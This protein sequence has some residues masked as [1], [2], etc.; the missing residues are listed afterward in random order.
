MKGVILQPTY[1]PWLGY[2]EMIAAAD[3]FIIYDHVQFVKK[4]WH[5]RN[6]IKGPN[7][8]ILLSVPIKKAPLNTPLSMTLLADGYEKTLHSHWASISH[9]YKKAKYFDDYLP[10]RSTIEVSKLPKNSNIEI[11]AI[12]YC[13]K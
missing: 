12:C 1:L 13:E 8:E 4:S 7:G 3:I 9:T 5:H 2:F 11:E 10:A 6:R